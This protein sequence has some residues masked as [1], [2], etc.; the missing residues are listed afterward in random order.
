[1]NELITEKEFTKLE[2]L[3][4][5]PET[6]IVDESERYIICKSKP[7]SVKQFDRFRKIDIYKSTPLA[8]I[9]FKSPTSNNGTV[10]VFESNKLRDQWMTD[11]V[12]SKLKGKIL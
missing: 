5:N 2:K 3:L 9:T 4:D 11:K 7:W 1:M 8:T 12:L 10:Y 6:H